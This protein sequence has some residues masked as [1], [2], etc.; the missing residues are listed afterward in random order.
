M[1]R[2]RAPWAVLSV[3]ALVIAST[4]LLPGELPA[5][6]L[7]DAV[8]AAAAAA[9]AFGVRRHRPQDP[10]AWYIIAAGVAVL[11]AGDVAWDLLSTGDSAGAV[12]EHVANVLY[13]A[14]YPL[15]ALG[16]LRL[17]R[18]RIARGDR[19]ALADSAIIVAAA[20][21]PAWQFLIEP[22]LDTPPVTFNTVAAI[23][24]PLLDLVLIGALA[25]V[26][27]SRAQ[28]VAVGL[29][30]GGLCV[31]LF[32]DVAYLRLL[33]SAADPVWLDVLW[34]ASYVLLGVSALH[35]SMR[36][37]SDP[38]PRRRPG[39]ALARIALLAS[40]LVIG[41]SVV[42]GEYLK[43]R[44]VDARVLGPVSA[45]VALLV[46]LRLIRAAIEADEA[47]QAVLESEER[48][49]SLVQ[50]ASDV[51][52][53]I[54]PEGHVQYVSPAVV[55]LLGGPPETYLGAMMDDHIHAA[56]LESAY[57]TL[58]QTLDNPGRAFV[59]EV[60]LRHQDGGWRWV[61]AVATGR[62]DEPSV[63]GVV[64]N[65]RNVTE[66]KRT[67]AI[68][69][70]EARVLD[71]IARSAPLPSTLTRLIHTIEEQ[72]GGGRCSIRL[73]GETGT[74]GLAVAPSLPAGYMHGLEAVAPLPADG[75]LPEEYVYS[76]SGVI[77]LAGE[78]IPP[79]VRE[80]AHAHGLRA[81]WMIPIAASE[82]ARMLGGLA[83]YIDDG[84]E[85]SPTDVALVER[86]AAL[87]AV[88][89]DRAAAEDRLEHQALHDPLTGL[90]NRALVLDRLSQALVRLGR[91]PHEM[92]AVLFLDLDRFKVINDSLGHD[93]GDELLVALGGRLAA[94][95][96][97]EDTVARFGGD[98]FVI[99]CERIVQGHEAEALAERIAHSL[100]QPFALG[101]GEVVVTAS[102][103]IA[104]SARA[105]DR[106]E[107]LLRDA[108]AAMYR[109]KDRGGAHYELFDHTMHTKAVVRLLTERA[110]RGALENDELRLFFQPQIHL[111]T[112][113][114]VSVE[115]LVRWEHSVRGTVLP[116]DFIPVAEET[117]LI[118]PI[119]DKVLAQACAQAER[120][121]SAG[122][123]GSALGVSI[124]LSV[125]QL[126]RAAL[127]GRI[128]ALLDEHRL[129]P[130][131][132]CLEITESVLLDDVDTTVDALAALK[133][134]GVRLAIDDFGTGYSSLSYLKRFPFDELKIDATF[135][136]GLGQSATDDA[137]VAATVDMAHALG[138]AA[139]AEGVETATQLDRLTAL[140]CD[141]AQGF[142]LAMPEPVERMGGLDAIGA[143]AAS[144]TA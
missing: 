142:H 113:A 48:F 78:R 12:P 125:R 14:A 130:A 100:D 121:R 136:A 83:A 19:D 30:L 61:E 77:D 29:F 25:R 22:A 34:P 85:P 74:P 49:R 21:L 98:E 129:D 126:M 52:V 90:P 82:D 112:S 96:R 86:A 42:V 64:C 33:P 143:G 107:S 31:T 55:D 102:I 62:V 16:L 70:D 58:G 5:A 135:V 44:E 23:L 17:V 133:D 84:A 63:R 68:R 65:L 94:V 92:V 111:A 73:L 7:R 118:V 2:A 4:L 54:A 127:P 122:P 120:W 109:A 56:D 35:P 93:A 10:A 51:I 67:E 89:I 88:A 95:L 76:K 115:A 123:D 41:P 60:R 99:V 18:A 38:V 8:G 137:I 20:L 6:L 40:A 53:V 134:L 110:L 116:V 9:I 108:D 81:C 24:F 106:A 141:L 50:H 105:G 132:I 103:G 36:A 119:G 79:E 140:G 124:N 13:L 26:M 3:G 72:L 43:G 97:P 101:P 28:S 57:E 69:A 87:A 131:S 66:R 144:R 1:V 75:H 37:V 91:H 46:M 138:M 32:A 104:V 11:V 45:L 139:A 59:V 27:F 80:L 117:G 128:R 15:L 71:M 39:L 47:T 114:C